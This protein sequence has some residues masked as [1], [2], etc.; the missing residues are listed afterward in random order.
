MSR[1]SRSVWKYAIHFEVPEELAPPAAPGV[2][3]EPELELG[4]LELL[5]P[6]APELGGLAPAPEL[7]LS[8]LEGGVVDPADP[9]APA[10][11]E[12][13]ELEDPALGALD[14]PALGELDEPALGALEE[15]LEPLGALDDPALGA[16]EPP[17]A[18]PPAWSPDLLQPAT[19]TLNRLAARMILEAFMTDF[20]IVPFTKGW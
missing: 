4:G 13:G 10:E 3:E 18:P 8:E 20:I 6:D 17:G 12:L 5:E 19:I 11:P 14:D 7:E 1:L 2:V 16:L 15:E 9:V